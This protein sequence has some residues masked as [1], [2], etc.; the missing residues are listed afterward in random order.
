MLLLK[1]RGA[2]SDKAPL[3]R[4]TAMNRTCALGLLATIALLSL[5]SFTQ[6]AQAQT[7]QAS[8]PQAAIS[9][10]PSRTIKMLVGFPPGGPNDQLARLLGLRLADQL[11]QTIVIENK[12]GAN[13]EIAATQTAAATPDGY[14]LL[15][16]SSGALAVSPSLNSNLPYDP[17]KDLTPISMIA[18]NPMLLV[19]SPKSG[20]TS[21]AD[22]IARAKAQPGK[23]TFASAGT[24]S[25]TH[26][27]CELFRDI[28]ANNLL[29][30]PY[31][32]GSDAMIAVVGG[33]IESSITTLV[34]ANNF[35]KAGTLRPLAV[36]SLQRS[37]MYPDLPTIHEA[38]GNSGYEMYTWY[39]AVVR[40]G[41]PKPIIDRLNAELNKA[42]NHPEMRKVLN[43]VGIELVGGTPEH[44]GQ[45]IKTDVAKYGRVIK[46]ANLTLD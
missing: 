27:A 11:K 42:L 14:T 36:S 46:D 38:T 28:A 26:L 7:R 44:F 21:V 17:L 16:G 37:P 31:K 43:T 39:G 4:L 23:L 8:D 32:G 13:G 41:T 5:A 1:Q 25:P 45:I 20:I 2:K 19:T 22:L 10:Y 24:G 15:F 34:T 12:A 40:A 33:S 9:Q 3:P 29:H 30:V 6:V 35:V 18:L